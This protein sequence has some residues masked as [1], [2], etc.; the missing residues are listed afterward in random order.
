MLNA[1]SD[2]QDHAGDRSDN[3][4]GRAG[5]EEDA[6]DGASRRTHGAQDRDV[7]RLV[8]HQHDHAGNDI[9]GGDEDDERQDEEHH[10]AL[11][12][13]RGEEGLVAALPGE[14]RVTGAD[15]VDD[16]GKV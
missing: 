8:L 1:K 14:D 7:V 5:H 3:A 9:E 4:D 15:R 11:D 13:E 12:R 2:A 10:V 6:L 16:G